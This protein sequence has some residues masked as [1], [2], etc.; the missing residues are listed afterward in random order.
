MPHPKELG[1]RTLYFTVAYGIFFIFFIY[2]FYTVIFHFLAAARKVARL[3]E[4][5][6][7]PDSGGAAAPP[8]PS[9]YVYKGPNVF[10]KSSVNSE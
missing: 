6:I 9:S 4:K 7:L 2:N 1:F 3:P 10:K 8:A 5:N